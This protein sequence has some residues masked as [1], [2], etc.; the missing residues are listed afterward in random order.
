MLKI[1]LLL[2][3]VH[4]GS[5]GTAITQYVISAQPF[6]LWADFP[7]GDLSPNR[8]PQLHNRE[9]SKVEE[10]EEEEEEGSFVL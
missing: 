4:C 1:I 3:K 2:K 9:Q 5:K 10:K 8:R 7:T 6:M